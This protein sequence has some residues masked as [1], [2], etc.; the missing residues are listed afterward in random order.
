MWPCIVCPLKHCFKAQTIVI[1]ASEIQYDLFAKQ[2]KNYH[3]GVNYGWNHVVSKIMLLM[4]LGCICDGAG[5]YLW[6]GWAVFVMA[7]GKDSMNECIW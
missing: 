3:F 4:K 5:L 7:E 1:T 6:R 2:V